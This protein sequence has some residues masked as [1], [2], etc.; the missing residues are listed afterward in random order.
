MKDGQ[1]YYLPTL[2]PPYYSKHSW[3]ING[4]QDRQAKTNNMVCTTKQDA[5]ALSETLRMF[6]QKG[7]E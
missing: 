3:G 5:E 6:L 7:G 4:Y 1:L 2:L